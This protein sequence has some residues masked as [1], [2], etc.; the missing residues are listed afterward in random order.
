MIA[1]DRFDAGYQPYR[2]KLF[3]QLEQFVQLLLAADI[4]G[5]LAIDGSFFTE[6][7]NPSDVDVLLTLD[8]D[9]SDSLSPAQ[10]DLIN[11]VNETYLFDN[12]D[13]LAIVNYPRGHNL[14]GSA[15]DVAS[16]SNPYGIENSEAWTKGYV[17]LRLWETEIGC[18]IRN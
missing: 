3:Q 16:M 11:K 2:L 18:R 10:N 17:I 6:K 12:V 9:V 1:V 4:R 15:I 13:S 14:F 8:L 5:D 7:P